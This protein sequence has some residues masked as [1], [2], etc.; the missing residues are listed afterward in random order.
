VDDARAE[1]IR[2]RAAEALGD[3]PQSALIGMAALRAAAR[4]FA[5]VERLP[6][7][8]AAQALGELRGAARELGLIAQALE[9]GQHAGGVLA[10]LRRTE[11]A[12]LAMVHELEAAG[13]S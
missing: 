8:E 2:Q 11:T 10:A 9:R 1:A 3:L 7:A 4:V 13:R 12:A 5:R 6:G